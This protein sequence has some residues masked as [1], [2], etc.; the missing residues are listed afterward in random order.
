M[1]AKQR[2]NSPHFFTEAFYFLGAE[3]SSAGKRFKA[4]ATVRSRS[5]RSAKS[6]FTCS[7]DPMPWLRANYYRKDQHISYL[8]NAKITEP[9]SFGAGL[10]EQGS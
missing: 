3:A 9:S 5:E 4:A 2:R 7:L 8:C 1:A 10:S 6:A